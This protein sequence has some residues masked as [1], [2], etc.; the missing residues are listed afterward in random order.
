MTIT[1]ALIIHVSAGSLAILSG[2][3]ALTVRKGERLH[4][5]FGTIF[6]LSMLTTAAFA[7]YLAVLIP[8]RNNI[9]GGIFVFYLVA[10][11][12]VTVRRK[13]GTI[14]LFEYG[15]LLVV[16]GAA[17]ADLIF[18]LRAMNNAHGKLD[19]FPAAIYFGTASVAALAAV[20]D[21]KVILRGGIS[22]A[23]RIARHLW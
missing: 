2:A 4:R 13:E 15:A 11:A 14:R 7:T 9:V 18:G 17:A 19:G 22:G 1:P 21:L 20:F 8:Q 23:P 10:S 16:L 5:I 3:V 6:F 12:W